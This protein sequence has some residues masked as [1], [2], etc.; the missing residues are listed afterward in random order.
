MKHSVFTH[1]FVEAMPTELDEGR[2]YVSI[3]YRTAAH[4]CACGC[5]TKVVTPIKPAK[6]HLI[7]DGDTVSLWPS[8][9]RWQEPCR[10]HYWIRAG[11]VVWSES[12]TEDE[13][14]AGRQ[15]DADNLHRYYSA[16]Q[17]TAEDTMEP[18][19]SQ[20]PGFMA[21]LRQRWGRQ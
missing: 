2:L 20:K 17:H 11:R 19:P 9:G 3:R 4:L 7:Y 16:R 1:E 10:S 15:R 18:V 8:I 14:E 13:I 21:R 5:G 6:W 12:W